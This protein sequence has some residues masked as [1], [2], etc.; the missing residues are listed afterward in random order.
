MARRK[1]SSVTVYSILEFLE[2]QAKQHLRSASLLRK[3]IAQLRDTANH[4]RKG[5]THAS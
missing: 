1:K 2:N 4:Q 5:E 3:L